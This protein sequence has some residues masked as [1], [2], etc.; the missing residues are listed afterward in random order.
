[1]TV[2]VSLSGDCGLLTCCGLLEAPRFLY[3]IRFSLERVSGTNA[4]GSLALTDGGGA[5]GNI[6]SRTS[7][8]AR[9]R[10][11]VGAGRKGRGGEGGRVGVGG[12]GGNRE[13]PPTKH[14]SMC[15]V[16]AV[17]LGP[18][19]RCLHRTGLAGKTTGEAFQVAKKEEGEEKKMSGVKVFAAAFRCY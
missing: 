11:A 10:H 6:R 7:E 17:S 2:H 12:S 16:L 15:S 13:R 4:G 18:P 9:E 5:L 14:D 3:S 8:R 19:T 1:M